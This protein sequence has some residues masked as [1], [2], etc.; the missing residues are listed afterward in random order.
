MAGRSFTPDWSENGKGSRTT[1][2][3]STFVVVGIERVVPDLTEVLLRQPGAP[4][5]H[6]RVGLTIL[7]ND[8]RY[9]SVRCQRYWLIQD[10]MFTVKMR[11]E[12]LHTNN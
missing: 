5:R 3:R 7:F 4:L 9:H 2:P 12:R 1:V 10:N 6:V 8:N 11:A